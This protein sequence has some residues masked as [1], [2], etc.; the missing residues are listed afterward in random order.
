MRISDGSSDMCSSDRSQKDF[1]SSLSFCAMRSPFPFFKR[2]RDA[3]LMA[4]RVKSLQLRGERLDFS[5]SVILE[6]TS[7]F[8]ASYLARSEIS[9]KERR[10]G[11]K[12]VCTFCSRL[13]PSL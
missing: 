3:F 11:D 4:L 9:S 12:C 10:V 6:Q 5:S 7:T 1:A 8:F 2:T 13:S